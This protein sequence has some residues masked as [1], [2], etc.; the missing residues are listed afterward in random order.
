MEMFKKV[1]KL[2]KNKNTIK[3]LTTVNANMVP[4]SVIKNSI[5]CDSEGNLLYLE[6]FEGSKTN[7]N[8]TYSLW[9]EKTVSILIFDGD[10]TVLQIKGIPV[11]VLVAGKTF[12]HYYKKVQTEWKG[13]DLAAVYF[14]KINNIIDE[15]YW[16]K[17]KEN[18]ELHPLYL[19]LD[20]LAIKGSE[21]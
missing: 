14:I 2:L 20:Q 16:T 10:E 21:D 6:L 15:S 18:E 7:V 4:H 9:F 13:Q 19:H 11:K 17:K 3:V 5:Q 1:K 8:M 12:E